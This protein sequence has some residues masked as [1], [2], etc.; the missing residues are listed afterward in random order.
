MKCD[1]CQKYIGAAVAIVTHEYEGETLGR[2]CLS[3]WKKHIQPKLPADEDEFEKK[4]QAEAVRQRIAQL[5]LMAE[6]MRQ[7]ENMPGRVEP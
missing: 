1:L 4:M 7:E 3:C 2:Y 6:R 5:N